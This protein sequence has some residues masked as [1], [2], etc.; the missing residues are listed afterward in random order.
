[1]EPFRKIKLN[2]SVLV[3]N[4]DFNPINIA[5]AKKAIKLLIKR[6]AEFISEK[7]IRLIQY[8]YLPVSRIRN[9]KPS[10][11]SIHMRD[12]NKCVYCH[13][14]RNLTIDHIIPKSRGGGD[15]YSNLVSA[16]NYCNTK[17]G[18]KLLEETNM[19]LLRKPTEPK[20][21]L[22]FILLKCRE[23]EWGLYLYS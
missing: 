2:S 15:T 4:Q 3:L 8:I 6:K 21:R 19:K 9:T 16:C 17:K 18:N 20:T 23:P 11:K 10:R 22:D 13:S 7:V 12:G 1:M 5:N 14:T